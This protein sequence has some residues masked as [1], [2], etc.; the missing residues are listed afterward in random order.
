MNV[1]LI[2]IK[3]ISQSKNSVMWV[4]VSCQSWTFFVCVFF[5]GEGVGGGLG[6]LL[7]I[8]LC[9]LLQIVGCCLM[10]YSYSVSHPSVFGCGFFLGGVEDVI[11]LCFFL[12]F[13]T[14]K[15]LSH[16]HLFMSSF[17]MRV[18]FSWTFI[19]TFLCLFLWAIVYNVF[20]MDIRFL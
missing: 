20:Y 3:D 16:G 1:Y 11:Y 2:N 18:D 13:V 7:T 6:Q 14:C 8:K 4:I 10:D 9:F 19:C 17:L 12:H 15:S 5:G